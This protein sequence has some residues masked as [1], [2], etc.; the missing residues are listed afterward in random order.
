MKLGAALDTIASHYAALVGDSRACD[1]RSHQKDTYWG[2][3]DAGGSHE[4]D[5]G[6]DSSHKKPT[7][8][9]AT[10][11]DGVVDRLS[12]QGDTSYNS[13]W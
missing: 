8:A 10:G 1:Q 7:A 2:I 4:V 5:Y 13:M 3:D 9:S 12:T 6:R 11:F